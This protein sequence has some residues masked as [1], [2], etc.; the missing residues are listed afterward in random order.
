M[1][2]QM[3]K[4]AG[5]GY[6]S[7]AQRARVITESWGSQNLFC[8]ACSA[9]HVCA[10]PANTRAVDYCCPLCSQRFQL[11]GKGSPITNKVLDGAYNTMLSALR[12][13]TAPNLFLL[14]YN[15]VSWAV[16]NLVLIPHFALPPSALEPRRALK[17]S[18][19]R[20]G[21]VG[22]FIV[23]SNIPP[24]ARVVVVSNGKPSPQAEVRKRFQRLRPLAA[25]ATPERGWMLDVYNLVQ[26]IGKVEFTNQEVY[27]NA[28]KIEATHPNNR[29]IRDKLRQQLQFLRD[30]G[31]LIHVE[32][33][34]WRL[35]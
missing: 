8:P 20:A 17:P 1:L 5:A 3:S 26:G 6:K 34:R 28:W 9:D 18:A 19:R 4:Q 16:V 11:R 2:I 32:P 31:L 13:D 7:L 14:Q 23:L 27:D 29:H 15:P 30:A 10:T 24:D 12:S 22:C 25:I 33:G 21:W 35:C